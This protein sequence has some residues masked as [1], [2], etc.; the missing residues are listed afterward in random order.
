MTTVEGINKT[1][2]KMEKQDRVVF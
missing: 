2:K 1:S